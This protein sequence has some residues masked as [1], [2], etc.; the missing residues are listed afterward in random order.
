MPF[1]DKPSPYSPTDY[2]DQPT[3]ELTKWLGTIEG[4]PHSE[5]QVGQMKDELRSRPEYNPM[6]V[7][8]PMNP[9][10]TIL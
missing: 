10:C 8:G 1:F 4:T 2:S 3:G 6:N 9:E 7:P 5:G